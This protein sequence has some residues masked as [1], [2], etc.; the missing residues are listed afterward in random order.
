MYIQDE[1]QKIRGELDI[2]GEWD[3]SY[4]SSQMWTIVLVMPEIGA[5][6]TYQ[7]KSYVILSTQTYQ[8]EL[9]KPTITTFCDILRVNDEGDDM[10]EPTIKVKADELALI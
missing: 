3:K 6:V 5:Y 1:N 9:S 2:P 8:E 10:G 4:Q 7:D